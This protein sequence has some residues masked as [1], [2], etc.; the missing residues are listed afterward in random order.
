VLADISI[1]ARDFACR[2][3]SSFCLVLR[4]H[5]EQTRNKIVSLETAPRRG[6]SRSRP[7]NTLVPRPRSHRRAP[8]PH[9][10]N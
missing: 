10:R 3:P 2:C 7:R 1:V 9:C 4:R 5:A 8:K 6:S